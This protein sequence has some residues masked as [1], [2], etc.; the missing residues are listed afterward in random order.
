MTDTQIRELVKGEALR[1]DEGAVW[2]VHCA[3]P[4]TDVLGGTAQAV[5]VR[6]PLV[7]LLSHK[8][9]LGWALASEPLL[10]EEEMD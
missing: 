10:P 5:V 8:N 3:A 2:E 7:T 9:S 4:R 1:D 6:W